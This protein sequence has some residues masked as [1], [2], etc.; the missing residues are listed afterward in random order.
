MRRE[1]ASERARGI[2]DDGCSGS[3]ACF[4]LV[5]LCKSWSVLAASSSSSKHVSLARDDV[6]VFST[7]TMSSQLAWRLPV[8][9]HGR[10]NQT[11]AEQRVSI[12][13]CSSYTGST[14]YASVTGTLSINHLIGA[15][16]LWRHQVCKASDFLGVNFLSFCCSPPHFSSPFLHHKHPISR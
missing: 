14:P 9:S 5:W 16:H 13:L 8:L 11:R 1:R 7:K 12:L 2:E 10:S 3:A 6:I 15:N 4:T